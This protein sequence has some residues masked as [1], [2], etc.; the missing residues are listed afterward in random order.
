MTVTSS[1]WVMCWPALWRSRVSH[2]SWGKCLPGLCI[3][4]RPLPE[5][6][7]PLMVSLGHEGASGSPSWPG[8]PRAMLWSH[9]P[10]HWSTCALHCAGNGREHRQNS[11][12]MHLHHTPLQWA[13]GSVSRTPR[14]SAPRTPHYFPHPFCPQDCKGRPSTLFLPAC[15]DA[16]ASAPPDLP[17]ATPKELRKSFL[18]TE[19]D[20]AVCSA[21]GNSNKNLADVQNSAA[22]SSKLTPARFLLLASSAE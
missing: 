3:L 16:P 12:D 6:S 11:R 20:F 15:Q 5:L 1:L 18:H 22:C 13:G 19:G 21:V 14:F 9:L 17:L 2:C 4:A 7:A 10:C 8:A